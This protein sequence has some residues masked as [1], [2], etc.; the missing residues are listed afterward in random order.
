MSMYKQFKTNDNLEIRGIIL[1]YGDFRVTIARAGGA[2]KRYDKILDL[3][4]KPYKRAIQLG[5][6]SAEKDAELMREVYAEAVIL[7]WEVVVERDEEDNRIFKEGIEAPNG[8][9]IPFSRE[10]VLMTLKNLPDLM[11]DIQ[12]QA[13]KVSLFREE[14]LEEDAK[15]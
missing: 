2:N 7:K 11:K 13:N 15:N 5:T 9:V 4:A 1:D 12:E 14:E 8:S 6:I 10:N 3:K